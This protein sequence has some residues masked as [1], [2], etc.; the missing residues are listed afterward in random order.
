LRKR[1]DIDDAITLFLEHEGKADSLVSVGEI[2]LENPHIAKNVKDGFV[3]PFLDAGNIKYNRQQL[4][5]VYFPYGV[6][7]M[8]E[9]GAYRR[10]RTFYQNRTLAYPIERW[11]NYEVDDLFD[12]ICISAIMEEKMGEMVS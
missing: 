1:N 4:D 8:S 11:Q 9:I 10:F 7:Y 2:H 3:K 5:K 12:L 6:L